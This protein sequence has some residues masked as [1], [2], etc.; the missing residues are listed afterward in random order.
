MFLPHVRKKEEDRK[1]GKKS[2][3]EYPYM[4]KFCVHIKLSGLT[5][6][7]DDALVLLSSPP[8]TPCFSSLVH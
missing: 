3:F 7:V 1:R 5:C 2:L 4:L 6:S 8:P